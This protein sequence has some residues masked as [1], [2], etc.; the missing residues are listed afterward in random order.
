MKT[1]KQLREK[2]LQTVPNPY[3]PDDRHITIDVFK[4]P[5]RKEIR[6][7]VTGFNANGEFRAFLM[8]NGDMYAWG[9]GSMVHEDM[10]NEMK[11]INRKY[12]PIVGSVRG[13][14]VMCRITGDIYHTIHNKIKREVAD[15]MVKE[16]TH[17]NKLF[18]EIQLQRQQGIFR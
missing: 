12:I 14:G 3:M 2:W 6:E 5:S 1:F 7:S 13:Y 11:T 8:D 15:E 4:N 16:H 10:H 9:A 17:L 18:P